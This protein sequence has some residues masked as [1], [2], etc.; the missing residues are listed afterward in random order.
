MLYVE[1][2]MLYWWIIF[3]CISYYFLARKTCAQLTFI[4]GNDE[5]TEDQWI[6]DN[7][8]PIQYTNWDMGQP[9]GGSA[10]NYIAILGNKWHDVSVHHSGAWFCGKN[11]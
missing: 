5:E 2:E 11:V 10:E 9:Q 4:Q 7:G 1:N 8:E 3:K 6:F